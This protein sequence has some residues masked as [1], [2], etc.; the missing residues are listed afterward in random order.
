[1]ACS[2]ANFTFT[3]AVWLHLSCVGN[4]A[5]QLTDKNE[6]HHPFDTKKNASAEFDPAAGLPVLSSGGRY[7]TTFSQRT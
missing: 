2:R 4:N 6:H 1:V 5:K 3:F 7:E